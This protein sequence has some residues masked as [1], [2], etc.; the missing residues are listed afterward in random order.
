MWGLNSGTMRSWPKLKSRLRHL[1]EWATQL[2]QDL[3]FI[4]SSLLSMQFSPANSSQLDLSEFS[5]SYPQLRKNDA[6]CLGPLPVLWLANS[7]LPIH[8][9]NWGAHLGFVFFFPCLRNQSPVLS[10]GHCL[11]ALA[12]TFCLG[13]RGCLKW[14]CKWE[15]KLVQPLWKRVWRFLKK[16]KIELPYNPAIA[17]VGIY[18]RVQVCCFKGAHAPCVY[19]STINNSQSMERAQMSIDG[20]TYE[21][22]NG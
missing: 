22:M 21:W 4:F 14:D 13:F 17:L 9:I 19:S 20:W 18:P 1:T 6:I 2:P 12:F 3:F 10:A 5:T 7:L 16:L 8:W 15:C 11:K